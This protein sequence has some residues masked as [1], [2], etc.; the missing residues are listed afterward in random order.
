MSENR[1]NEKKQYVPHYEKSRMHSVLMVLL[2]L[3]FLA[4]SYFIVFFTGFTLGQYVGKQKVFSE[5]IF[6]QTRGIV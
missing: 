3:A 4:L 1:F 2:I 6:T 5:V